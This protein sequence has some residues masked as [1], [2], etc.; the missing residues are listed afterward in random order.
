[1]RPIGDVSGVDKCQLRK[2]QE[3]EERK[4]QPAHLAAESDVADPW[5]RNGEGEDE[6]GMKGFREHGCGHGAL[7][8]VIH[9]LR[10][11]FNRHCGSGE[12]IQTSIHNS[13]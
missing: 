1:M 10:F 5:K 9:A 3:R 11:W 6:I 2:A 8:T 13:L 7:L 4:S 12:A